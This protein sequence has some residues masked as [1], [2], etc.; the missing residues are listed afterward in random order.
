MNIG[1]IGAGNMG[2]ALGRIW[3]NKNHKVMFSFMRDESQLRA[4]A[5]SIGERASSGTPAEA[6][7]FGDIVLLSVPWNAIEE[8]VE[9]TQG[10]LSG[11]VVIS[12][13]NPL[14]PDMSG[15]QVGTTTSGAEEVAR[16][17]MGAN[18]VEVLFP[19]AD[20]LKSESVEFG[21]TKPTQFFCGDD[22]PA[23]VMVAQLISDVELEPVDAGPL[24]CAR[25]LEPL[26][27]LLVQL[28]YT[29]QMGQVAF[30]LLR[31]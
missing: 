23:K 3:T 26:G 21:T 5:E 12:C 13:N 6:A 18:V 28:A 1:I 2:G 9:Q 4:L 24:S 15:L 19:F 25:Y 10:R 27:M 14:K 31:K 16:M 30:K 17:A 7:V 22:V 11:K 8:A 20:V 29:Q